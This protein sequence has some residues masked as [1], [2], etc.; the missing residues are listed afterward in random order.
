MQHKLFKKKITVI[1]NK[2]GVNTVKYVAFSLKKYVDLY[3]KM[4]GPA[5]LIFFLTFLFKNLNYL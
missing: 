2:P 1:I 5:K 3:P 4:R